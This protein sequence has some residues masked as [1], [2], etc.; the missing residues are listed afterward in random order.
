MHIDLDK[1]NLRDGLLGLVMTL[2]EVIRDALEAQSIKRM[3]GGRLTDEQ[4]EKL[5]KALIEL[6]SAIES[7][8]NKHNINGVVSDIHNQLDNLVCD[9]VDTLKVSTELHKV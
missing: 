1:D 4:I 9:I 5:G 7:I 3:E 6:N 8:K 2:V